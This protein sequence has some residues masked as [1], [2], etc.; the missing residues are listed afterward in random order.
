MQDAQESDCLF[1][2]VITALLAKRMGN[3]AMFPN[4]EVYSG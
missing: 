2:T 4:I 1:G 3:T